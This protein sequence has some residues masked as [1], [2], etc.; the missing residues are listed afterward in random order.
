MIATIFLIIITINF[1]CI[2]KT[3]PHLNAN[4]SY[5]PLNPTTN[6]I[7]QFVD[8]STCTNG[9]IVN[10]SWDFD[11]SNTY[12]DKT[13]NNQ[14]TSFRYGRGFNKTFHVQL[15]IEDNKGRFSNH[16]KKI[17][18]TPQLYLP[19]NDDI[20]LQIQSI[21]KKE[22]N[23]DG[24]GSPNSRYICL[25][26]K[27]KMFNQWNKSL[28]RPQSGWAGTTGWGGNFYIYTKPD[29]PKKWGYSGISPIGT[30]EKINPGENTSW[31][32]TFWIPEDEQEFKITYSY[33][34]D[35]TN[36]GVYKNIDFF[37]LL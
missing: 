10:W 26:A 9:Y 4:F 21:E 15:T 18:I 30:P 12:T 2:T 27:I 7:I 29:S 19:S 32:I 37:V 13:S 6:D 28:L 14:H 17:T 36:D 20:L 34:Y 5:Y 16:S 1:G 24:S 31:M 11:I 8:E 25:W 3:E 22:L 23:I 35:T 33:L